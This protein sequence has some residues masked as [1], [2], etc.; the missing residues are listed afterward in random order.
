MRFKLNLNIY[1][2]RELDL[3]M[4]LTNETCE[5]YLWNCNLKYDIGKVMPKEAYTVKL[6][7]VPT[8]TGLIVS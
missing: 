2:E 6:N 1:R 8:K 3:V 7:I 5:G 4:R